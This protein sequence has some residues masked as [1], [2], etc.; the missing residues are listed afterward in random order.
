M[1]RRRAALEAV[2]AEHGVAHLLVYGANRF[3]SAV[4]WLTR[5]PVTR[6][7]LVVVT[8]GERDALF[9]DFYNHVP[10]ARRIATEADVRPAGAARDRDRG[11]RAPRPRRGGGAGRADRPA[12][13][14]RARAARR[15]RGRGSSTSTPRTRAC[16]CASRPRRSNGCAPAA[17]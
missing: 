14:P 8:P 5:W 4:G 15:A 11:R 10:N 1:A 17:S 3:G 7:A 9:V 6:E 12:R 2:M 16:A 13:P